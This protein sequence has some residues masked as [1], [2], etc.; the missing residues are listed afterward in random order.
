MTDLQKTV[1][2]N[3]FDGTV[4]D[5]YGVWFRY[6]ITDNSPIDEFFLRQRPNYST[7]EPVPEP[8]TMLLLGS[9]L[10]GLAGFRRRFRKK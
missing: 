8:A 9:G 4:D 1:Y 7:T 5:D 10:I 3:F 6:A 2:I